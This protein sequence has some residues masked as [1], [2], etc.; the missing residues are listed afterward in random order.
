VSEVQA[1]TRAAGELVAYARWQ[2]DARIAGTDLSA[3]IQ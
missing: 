2:R 3:G 1:F